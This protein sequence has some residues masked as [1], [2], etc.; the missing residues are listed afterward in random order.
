MSGQ[1]AVLAQAAMQAAGGEQ[2]KQQMLSSPTSEAMK[3]RTQVPTHPVPRVA[4]ILLTEGCF[5]PWW[6]DRLIW[7]LVLLRILILS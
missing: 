7:G 2:L 6:G 4:G 5:L 3:S 1:L